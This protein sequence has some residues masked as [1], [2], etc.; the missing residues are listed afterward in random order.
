MLLNETGGSAGV[1]AM[2]E[3]SPETEFLRCGEAKVVAAWLRGSDFAPR[4]SRQ[5]FRRAWLR[6]CSLTPAPRYRHVLF[7]K[8]AALH[9][10]Q[11]G[12]QQGELGIEHVIGREL[13]GTMKRCGAERPPRGIQIRLNCQRLGRLW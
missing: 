10:E 6:Q 7:D 9:R 3:T 5:A 8:A 4:T 11:K 12:G 13:R 1:F 2:A